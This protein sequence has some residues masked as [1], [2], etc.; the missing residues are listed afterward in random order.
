MAVMRKHSVLNLVTALFERHQIVPALNLWNSSRRLSAAASLFLALCFFQAPLQAQTI[1]KSVQIVC[2]P[3]SSGGQA[4]H[5]PGAVVRYK[6]TVLGEVNDNNILT[7]ENNLLLVVSDQLSRDLDLEPNLVTDCGTLDPI[8]PENG[9]APGTP[10]S[11]AGDTFK[12]TV[13]SADA[14]I[15]TTANPTYH[16]TNPPELGVIVTPPAAGAGELIV[17]NFTLLQGALPAV[18][19]RI[20]GELRA[21]EQVEI[22]FN[23]VIR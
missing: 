13:T 15:D 5:I 18:N 20:K 7:D 8:E 10:E 19:G 11:A 17:L 23:A 9:G 2:D 22:E 16:S 1:L 6:I 21:D 3:I 14:A 4:F 12:I